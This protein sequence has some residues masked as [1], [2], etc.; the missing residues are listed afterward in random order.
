MTLTPPALL[1]LLSARDAL[2]RA[3]ADL[4]LSAVLGSDLRL[5]TDAS[6]LAGAVE[7]QSAALDAM[8]DTHVC[9]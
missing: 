1:L 5:A 9:N 8:I 4:A 2:D 7:S 6:V 3:A